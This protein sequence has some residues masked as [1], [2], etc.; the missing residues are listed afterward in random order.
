MLTT[1]TANGDLHSRA[2]APASKE[3]PHVFCFVAN[4]ESG[5]F[6]EIE[7]SEDSKVRISIQEGGKER[8]RERLGQLGKKADRL[9]HFHFRKKGQR[10]DIR[11]VLYKLGLCRRKRQ[12]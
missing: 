5:K 11:Q 2:M 6:D 12:D 10:L 3:A 1:K 7:H 9:P 8:R 4:S